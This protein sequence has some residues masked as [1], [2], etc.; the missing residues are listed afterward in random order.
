MVVWWDGCMVG[1]LLHCNVIPSLGQNQTSQ[2]MLFNS[3]SKVMQTNMPMLHIL[4][5]KIQLSAL[6]HLGQFGVVNQ[7]NG[8]PAL[9]TLDRHLRRFMVL[10]CSNVDKCWLA[11]SPYY[12]P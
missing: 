3:T 9:V 5:D 11:A 7:S 1:C 2:L 12:Q 6:S 8:G 4:I 10:F